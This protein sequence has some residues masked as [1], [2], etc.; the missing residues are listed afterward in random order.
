[1]FILLAIICISILMVKNIL[2]I[3]KYNDSSKLI[4]SNELGD[5]KNKRIYDPLLINYTM[6]IPDIQEYINTHPNNYY[7]NNDNSMVRFSDFNNNPLF[8]YKN[9]K[10]YDDLKLKDICDKLF[11]NFINSFSYNRLNSVSIFYKKIESTVM[12]NKHNYKLIGCIHGEMDIF[13]YNPKHK[14]EIKEKNPE[15]YAIKTKLKMN[16]LLYIPTNWYYQ[17]K[18]DELCV[19]FDIECDNYFTFIFNEYRE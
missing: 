8:I 5:Y 18:T 13:L 4:K 11:D 12:K 15:K 6:D 16:Q 10:L 3:Y 7:T 14:K 2:D 9:T 17:F 1:M 19:F